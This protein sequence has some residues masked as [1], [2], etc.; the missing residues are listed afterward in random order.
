MQRDAQA[1]DIMPTSV[2][3]A[4]MLDWTYGESQARIAQRLVLG[5]RGKTFMLMHNLACDMLTLQVWFSVS[6]LS[7]V[8]FHSTWCTGDADEGFPG[9]F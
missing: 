3:R 9:I 4:R 5:S 2:M 1:D 8:P 7:G 6:G